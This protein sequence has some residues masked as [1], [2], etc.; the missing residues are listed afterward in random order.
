MAQ[1][2]NTN[3]SV[4][5]ETKPVQVNVS[6]SANEPTYTIAEFALAPESIKAKNADIVNAALSIRGKDSFTI[7]EATEILK[8]FSNKEVK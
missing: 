3:K 8:K 7:S 4:D 6:R 2:Q 1:K 5:S